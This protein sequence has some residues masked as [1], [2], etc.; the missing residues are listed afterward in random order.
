MFSQKKSNSAGFTLVEL[1]VVVSI[2]ST[3]ASTVL[4][5]LNEARIKARNAAALQ[6]VEQYKLAFELSYDTD[7]KYPG[8]FGSP[9]L[10]VG[11]GYP[12]AGGGCGFDPP[13]PPWYAYSQKDVP[14]NNAL[15][16]FIPPLP[17]R[18]TA[19][20]SSIGSYV[21]IESSCT[22]FIPAAT[23]CNRGFRLMWMLEGA[24][25]NCGERATGIN[26]GDATYCTF[27][28]SQ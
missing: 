27:I 16:R 21:G 20:N 23:A 22:P 19:V 1:L 15:A 25:Q 3:L 26:R 5:S 10:C 13:L 17:P 28:S 11:D 9:W 6:L 14:L 4:A 8:R 12:Y 24:N 2:I 7:G 18:L